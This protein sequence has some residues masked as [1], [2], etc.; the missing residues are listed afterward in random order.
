[1]KFEIRVDPEELVA[2]GDPERVHQVVANLIDNAI[3]HSPEGGT[4]LLHAEAHGGWAHLSVTDEGPG[5]RD[6]DVPR[7]FERF[8]R[9]DPGRS[10]AEG[11]TGLGLAIARWIVDLHGGNIRVEGAHPQGCCMVVDLPMR[12]G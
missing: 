9:T 4:V 11:G 8:Y 2:F 6:E 1:V 12:A 5:I 3:R 7:V 10:S